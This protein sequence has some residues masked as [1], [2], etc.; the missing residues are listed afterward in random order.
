[1]ERGKITSFQ[2]FCLIAL[3]IFGSTSLLQSITAAGR[4]S[5]ISH[6]IAIFAGVFVGLI[7]T[8]LAVRFPNQTIIQYTQELFGSIA[9][10]IIG[11]MY[12]WYFLHLGAL[13]LRNY[14][15]FFT[16]M[17]LPETPMWFINLTFALVVAYMAAKGIEVIARVG[18]LFL[19]A[20]AILSIITSVL[21]SMSGDI[22]V[23]SNLKPVLEHGLTKVIQ[24]A[25][26]IAS[27][28]FMEI[29]LFSMFFPFTNII[30][31]SKNATLAGILFSGLFL[32]IILVQNIAVFGDYLATLTFPRYYVVR[33]ISVGGFVERIEPIILAIWLMGG[34]IK[35]GICFYAFTLGLSQITG[36]KNDKALIIPTAVLMVVLSI[37]IYDNTFE[38]LNFAVNIYPVYAFPFQVGLPMLMLVIAVVRGKGGKQKSKKIQECP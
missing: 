38:Q 37:L 24:G 25:V 10:K 8:T 6:I 11:I 27:F 34:L 18:E 5:W 3:F 20:L 32:T 19:P 21:I 22:V 23:A 31:K 28:P 29:I 26:P 30:T 17:V 2:L 7:I 12:L 14:G 13:V 15:E 33:I 16:N 4:D 36:M 35:I 9:G 1:M